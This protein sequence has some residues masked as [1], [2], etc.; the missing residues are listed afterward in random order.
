[1]DKVVAVVVAIVALMVFVTSV[2]A[3]VS[4]TGGG[5]TAL[6]QLFARPTNV[7][8][9]LDWGPLT[10]ASD[11]CFDAISIGAEGYVDLDQGMFVSIVTALASFMSAW[12]LIRV[13]MR[14][15]SL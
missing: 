11:W 14:L 4:V 10:V 9:P 6:S 12:V 3:F 15:V 8:G 1:M 2:A 13:V 5:E 7:S